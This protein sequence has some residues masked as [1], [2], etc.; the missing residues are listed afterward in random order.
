MTLDDLLTLLP[1][2]FIALVV[3]KKVHVDYIFAYDKYDF[4]YNAGSQID[5]GEVKYSYKSAQ[6]IK[7]IQ[8]MTMQEGQKGS[9]TANKSVSDAFKRAPEEQLIK[10]FANDFRMF[11]S[12]EQEESKFL[13]GLKY[14]REVRIVVET[15][16]KQSKAQRLFRITKSTV[17]EVRTINLQ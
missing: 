13:H 2:D 16:V 1:Q 11:Y 17:S 10:L 14:G 15:P 5:E 4:D 7:A 8:K 9:D 12:E 6:I 3:T